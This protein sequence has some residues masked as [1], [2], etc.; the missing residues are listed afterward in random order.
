MARKG[1]ESTHAQRERGR[2]R[3]GGKGTKGGRPS[4]VDDIATLEKAA[5]A[6]MF[7]LKPADFSRLI[8]LHKG[9]V[10]HWL[11]MG[12]TALADG[13][14]AE[15]NPY[16]NFRNVWYGAKI[17]G[18]LTV[19]KAMAESKDSKLL[20]RWLTRTDDEAEY[21]DQDKVFQTMNRQPLIEINEDNRV[22][23]I[24]EAMRRARERIHGEEELEALPEGVVEEVR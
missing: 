11:N 10:A 16:L 2:S 13:E 15:D 14:D 23:S 22:V 17:E 1:I 12:D 20:D 21:L 7:G 19:M 4:K 6:A 9:T 24:G 3:S 18:R 8:G 5:E